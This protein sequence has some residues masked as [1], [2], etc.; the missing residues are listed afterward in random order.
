MNDFSV[1]ASELAQAEN[2]ALEAVAVNAAIG[3]FKYEGSK[4]EMDAEAST[5]LTDEEKKLVERFTNPS[6]DGVPEV[7]VHQAT[8]GF[9]DTLSVMNIQQVIWLINNSIHLIEKNVAAYKQIVTKMH[10]TLV[11]SEAKIGR[12]YDRG[13][14]NIS[15]EFGAYSRF[16][17]IGNK[18]TTTDLQFIEGLF[19]HRAASEW[20]AMHSPQVLKEVAALVADVFPSIDRDMPNISEA[21]LADAIQKVGKIFD[22]H[23]TK[24]SLVGL[25]SSGYSIAAVR[26]PKSVQ[27]SSDVSSE[28]KGAMFDGNVVLYHQPKKRT[29]NNV[30]YACTIVRDEQISRT[31][32][33]G[34]D[35]EKGKELKAIIGHGVQ[36]ASN[37]LTSI[38]VLEDYIGDYLKPMKEAINYIVKNKM[39]LSTSDSKL[40]THYAALARLLNDA[41]FYPLLN[42]IWVDARLCRVIAGMAEAYFVRNPRDRTIFAKDMQAV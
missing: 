26:I 30:A 28:V 37:T 41:T 42:S 22:T 23:Y 32:V 15:I 12:L 2:T 21:L 10:K 17:H 29:L 9:L 36:I 5:G 1:I 19:V 6:E 35:I 33:R 16:F 4:F 27:Q 13:D 18:A 8:E 14:V 24:D 7:V 40:L 11:G 39:L 25:G 34:F 31:E 38:K 3:S 20:C